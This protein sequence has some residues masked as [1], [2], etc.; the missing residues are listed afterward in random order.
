MEPDNPLLDPWL[1]DERSRKMKRSV[2]LL[3]VFLVLAGARVF[4][5]EQSAPAV[6]LSLPELSW[7]LEIGA[8]GFV[9]EE[10]GMAPAGDAARLQASNKKIGV[11]LSAFLEKAESSG[12]AKECRQF[13]WNKGKQSPFKKEQIKMYEI[14]PIAA[15]EYLVPENRGVKINQQNINA[16]LAEGGYWIDVHLS[17]SDYKAG[18]EDPLQSVVKSIRINRAYTPGV[19]E[20]LGYGAMY[21]MKKDYKSAARQYE[22]ALEL[23]KKK[24]TLDRKLWKYLVDQLGMSYG[25]SGELA[26]SKQLYEWAIKEEPEFPMFYYNLACTNAEMGNKNEA[27]NNL[28]MAFKY[29]G[30]MLPGETL[31][32][33]K[34]DSS[35]KKYLADKQFSA[36]LDKMK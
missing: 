31:P 26:K 17:K 33:P 30:N 12:G 10:K 28:R 6:V 32:D 34:N 29:K 11:I 22:K 25:I 19:K 35:F 15:V 21:Y 36:E 23:E 8:P 2:A 5:Q 1:Q 20:L 27:L 24:A 9:V 7:C 18:A 16:Y 3:L 14:G 4:A 13:Y